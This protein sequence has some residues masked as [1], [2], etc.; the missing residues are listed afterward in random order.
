MAYFCGD[1]NTI[2]YNHLNLP[3]TI[4][5]TGAERTRSGHTKW[6]V[7]EVKR[8][9][10]P[11]ALRGASSEVK[12]LCATAKE[13]LRGISNVY[14]A[15][16]RK[17]QSTQGGVTTTYFGD[18]E[19]ERPIHDSRSDDV[20]QCVKG[21]NRESGWAGAIKAIY[22]QDGRI[23]NN[24]GS[25]EYQYYIKDHTPRRTC[26]GNVRIVCNSA[27]VI[28]SE[29]HYYP[30]GLN[31]EGNFTATGH[32]QKY[33][34]NGKE[35]YGGLGWY[36]YGARYYDPSVGRFTGV[37]PLADEPEQVDKSPY[38]YAWNNPIKYDD[39]D[40]RCPSCLFGALVGAAVEYGSQVVSNRIEGKSWSESF[41]DIDVADVAISAGE[42]FLTSGTSAVR[43]VVGKAAI[44]VG[45]EVIRNTVD[46]KKSGV[47][48]NDTKS[49]VRNTAIGLTV[50]GVS[51]AVPDPKIKVKAEVTPKQ[52]VK[53]ARE[54]GP[55]NRAG[56]QE[57]EK[58][59]KAT[60]KEAKAINKTASGT[61]ANAVSGSA[62]ETSKRKSD[63]ANGS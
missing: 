63:R 6:L 8:S 47:K 57:I 60:L 4:T 27:A 43:N 33:R 22:H 29:Q 2:T 61:P 48:V 34:Y 14:D 32:N 1:M 18:V 28:Q 3:H 44:K 55:V 56:R 46:L 45:A 25:Y 16:G 9:Y 13:L 59:A 38:A 15:P 41:T 20:R 39:P 17:W 5:G 12:T 21:V 54:A 24:A 42:G 36:D 11:G 50:A 10:R 37:D 40:G 23:L 49:V 62:S 7:G 35:L 52:A 30:F 31:M 51:K 19:Y 53:A 58:T 26:L